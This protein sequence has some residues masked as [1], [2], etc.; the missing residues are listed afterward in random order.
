MLPTLWGLPPA[1]FHETKCLGWGDDC[2]EYEIRWRPYRRILI[3]ILGFVAGAAAAAG[4]FV[5][6]GDPW[7][8]LTLP[9]LGGLSGLVY[10]LTRVLKNEHDLATETQGALAEAVEQEAAARREVMELTHRQNEWTRLMEQYASER[11]QAISDV[12]KRLQELRQ[13]REISIR[14]FSHDL[15]NPLTAIQMNISLMRSGFKPEDLEHML[16]DLSQSVER[17]QALIDELISEAASEAAMV[18]FEPEAIQQE[19]LVDMLR[20]RLMALTYGR[21]IS[22]SAFATREA[23]ASVEIDPIV[24]DRIVDNLLTNA[25]KY[26]V[27]GSIVAEIDGTPGFMTLKL[28]DTGRG[29]EHGELDRIFA[30]GGSDEG[31]RAA[32]SHGIGLSVVVQLLSTL[33]GRLEVMSKPG[34]GTTFWVHIP[35]KATPGDEKATKGLQAKVVHIRKSVES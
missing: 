6:S 34:V 33:G 30:P 22:V 17:M 14:G 27:R 8:S 19:T 29:I 1:E 12:V 32:G 18:R 2:C 9:V 15:K 10:E 16:A 25:A 7:L 26:T 31:A 28:S 3:P 5:F 13:T 23:P 21:H 24:L 20:R 35:E 4:A 11:T